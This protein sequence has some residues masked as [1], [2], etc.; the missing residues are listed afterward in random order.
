MNE[1]DVTTRWRELFRGQVITSELL[2]KADTLLNQLSVESPLR[3]RLAKELEDI[4]KLPGNAKPQLP[5]NAK[6][7]PA[8]ARKR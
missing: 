4:R 5:G 6:P 7:R 8:A 1:R 3:I 2:K